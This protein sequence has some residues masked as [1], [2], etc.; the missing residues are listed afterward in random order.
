[1]PN[2]Q[3]PV[4]SEPSTPRQ[5][6]PDSRKDPGERSTL[7]LPEKRRDRNL[8]QRTAHEPDR[9]PTRT[10]SKSSE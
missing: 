4:Q 1:M 3:D 2:S 10:H 7:R 6:D 8:P 9:E 5:R